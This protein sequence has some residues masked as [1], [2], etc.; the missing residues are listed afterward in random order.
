MNKMINELISEF[1][2]YDYLCS[3]N[4]VSGALKQELA[5]LLSRPHNEVDSWNSRWKG[6]LPLSNFNMTLMLEHCI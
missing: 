2:C 5:I 1:D 4:Q 3:P 6:T